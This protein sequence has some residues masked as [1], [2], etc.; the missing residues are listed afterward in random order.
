MD[1]FLLLGAAQQGAVPGALCAVRAAES[2]ER[3]ARRA[4]RQAAIWKLQPQAK[5]RFLGEQSYSVGR[6]TAAGGPGEN[7]AREIFNLAVREG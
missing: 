6:K 3:A 4:C 5:F 7:T 2:V 1:S